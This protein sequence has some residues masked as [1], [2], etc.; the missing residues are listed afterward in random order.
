MLCLK[1]GASLTDT[2]TIIAA[3]TG[4]YSLALWGH[5]GQAHEAQLVQL[6]HSLPLRLRRFSCGLELFQQ[7]PRTP[8]F[9]LPFFQSLTHFEILLRED[10]YPKSWSGL[11]ELVN[12]THFS[13]YLPDSAI[14]EE[15]GTTI[16]SFIHT[17]LPHLPESV[18][19]FMP[20][21]DWNLIIADVGVT[22]Q[23]L[24]KECDIRVVFGTGSEYETPDEGEDEYDAELLNFVVW[25]GYP[26]YLQDWGRLPEG[27][28]DVW[29]L[30]KI[31]QTRR[32]LLANI[33]A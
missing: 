29:E 23:W 27:A 32:R 18:Q 3:C 6:L 21:F 11:R 22:A 24:S 16:P 31:V 30:A 7:N 4:I 12:M 15:P 5:T 10:D 19:I 8:D 2:I 14:Y 13:L 25:R 9:T 28:L 17:V 33:A 26:S 20:F 1:N